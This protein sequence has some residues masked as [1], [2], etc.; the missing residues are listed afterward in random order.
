MAGWQA[1]KKDE[2]EKALAEIVDEIDDLRFN[3]K[4]L[5]QTWQHKAR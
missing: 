2:W 1:I 5:L 4:Q 3:L